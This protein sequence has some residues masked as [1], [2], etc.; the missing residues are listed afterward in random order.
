MLGVPWPQPSPD[1]LF[2]IG[3]DLAGDTLV[4][5]APFA[6]LMLPVHHGL[7][8]VLECRLRMQP[9]EARAA[10]G[11]GNLEGGRVAAEISK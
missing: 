7:F 8:L 2:Q 1:A 10:G 5:I 3:D 9:D 4:C 11:A 6:A